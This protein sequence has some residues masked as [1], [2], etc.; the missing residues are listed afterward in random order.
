M[1][2]ANVE[3]GKSSEGETGIISSEG[4]KTTWKLQCIVIQ[5]GRAME[6]KII[7]ASE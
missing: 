2:Y 6:R 5:L 4:I 3:K 7:R 1:S